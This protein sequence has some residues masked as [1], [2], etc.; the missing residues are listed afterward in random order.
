MEDVSDEKTAERSADGGSAHA[1]SDSGA[2]PQRA[3]SSNTSLQA[4]LELSPE[5]CQNRS[6]ADDAAIAAQ[7][8]RK[9]MDQ[10]DEQTVVEI[11]RA[12]DVAEEAMDRLREISQVDRNTVMD[13]DDDEV[14]E[15]SFEG[16][17][18]ENEEPCQGLFDD[19]EDPGPKR[20]FQRAAEEHGF[21]F[22]AFAST[23]ELSFYDRVRL[24]NLIRSRVKSGEE[25]S[26]IVADIKT[27]DRSAA[28]WSNDS[29]LIPVIDGDSLLT[30]IEDR[31]IAEDDDEV[32]TVAEAV[33]RTL[34]K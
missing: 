32:D 1:A 27:L 13:E 30:G 21:D 12:K 31:G 2:E 11:L 23:N 17:S 16:G 22:F 25:P 5:S 7:A 9:L 8:L 15:E 19:K 26:K 3:S 18:D 20:C 24:V 14:D 29:F 6:R 4:E 34:L 28:L 33:H 10:Y